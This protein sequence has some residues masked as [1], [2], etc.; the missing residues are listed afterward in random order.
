[1]GGSSS[2]TSGWGGLEREGG[3]S[4]LGYAVVGSRRDASRSSCGEKTERLG[5]VGERERG[6][7]PC[8]SQQLC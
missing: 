2:G 8:L 5:S 6:T 1:M 3:D 7:H 4:W